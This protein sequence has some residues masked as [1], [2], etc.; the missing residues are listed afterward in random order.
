[1]WPAGW[2][3]RLQIGVPHP[4]LSIKSE[5]SDGWWLRPQ[6]RSWQ[7]HLHS[8]QKERFEAFASWWSHQ[9]GLWPNTVYPSTT[10]TLNIGLFLSHSSFLRLC[11]FSPCGNWDK[12]K[13]RLTSWNIFFISLFWGTTQITILHEA[14]LALLDGNLPGRSHKTVLSTWQRPVS[15]HVTLSLFYC[16]SL[17]SDPMS[18]W[19]WNAPASRQVPCPHRHPW[20]MNEKDSEA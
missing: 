19:P 16:R 15:I 4:V 13:R 10:R 14:F 11:L 17:R 8:S 5:L 18:N 9:P 20:W 3:Y 12:G 7:L 1:M 6:L 2:L